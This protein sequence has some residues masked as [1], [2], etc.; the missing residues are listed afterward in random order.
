MSFKDILVH[1]DNHRGDE[2]R[3][4]L[5][6]AI[7]QQS[8]GH[9]VGI[10]GFELPRDP[11]PSL[12]SA[13]VYAENHAFRSSYERERDA[14]FAMAEQTESAFRATAK[15]AGL[16]ADWRMSPDKPTDLIGLVTAQAHYADLVVLGQA[17]PAHPLFDKLATLPETVMVDCGRPV[18]I[19]PAA[20]G[21][22]TVGKRV[23]IA[24]N[25]SREAARA[26]GDALPLLQAAQA[27][28]VLTIGPVRDFADGD[29]Q[30]GL[31]LV[32]HLARHDI[33]AEAAH[34][35]SGL[36]ATGDLIVSRAEELGCDLLV[37]GGYG[38]SRTRE[39]IL[40]GVTRDV[41]QHMT[42]PVLM[43]H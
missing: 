41:L 39:L 21:A 15:R 25:D 24:W 12:V 5:A 30:A 16:T 36:G 34:I 9:L 38:H 7:A 32:Q 10:Y 29:D 1:L 6:V 40:G 35:P 3:L 17:D 33:R 28:T 43:S 19:V 22:D 18:L 23:L 20:G 2:R 27:V 8:K 37:M 26:V 11:V 14:A 13:E 4:R 31:N 42:L